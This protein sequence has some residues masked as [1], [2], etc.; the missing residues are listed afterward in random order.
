MAGGLFGINRGDTDSDSDAEL[1]E[2]HAL[3]DE[4][5]SSTARRI[6]AQVVLLVL[7]VVLI[8][9]LALSGDDQDRSPASNSELRVPINGPT[10][11]YQGR[12]Y[13]LGRA[14]DLAVVRECDG[15][16][17]PWLLRPSTGELYRFD[18][19][20]GQKFVDAVRVREIDGATGLRVVTGAVCDQIHIE[21]ADGSEVVISG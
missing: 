18:G 11:D 16:T 13:R 3:V 20:A 9:V 1:N 15:V 6:G 8:V 7:A 4:V 2:I 21:V 19:W 14:G 10:I 12:Q 5:P 17:L